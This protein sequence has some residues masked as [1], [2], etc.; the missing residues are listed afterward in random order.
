VFKH[1]SY[2]DAIN[3]SPGQ[4]CLP[5]QLRHQ[6]GARSRNLI[7]M[8]L[9]GDDPR[10]TIGAVRNA[11]RLPVVFPGW[12]LRFY[13]RDVLPQLLDRLRELGA[14]LT[15]VKG[16]SGVPPMLWRMSA[17]DDPLVDVLLSRDADSRLTDR[18]AADVNAWMMASSRPSFH[19]I[20][21]HPSHAA[22]AA[23]G[24]LWG[25][26][27]RQLVRL[28]SG[29]SITALMANF[30]DNYLDD[31]KFLEQHIWRPLSTQF[32]YEVYCHDSVSCDKWVG[33]HPSVTARQWP[34]EHVGQVFDAW[35]RPRQDDVDVL[36]RANCNAKCESPE[37]QSNHVTVG[38]DKD[39]TS[40]GPTVH[41]KICIN[42][43]K[44]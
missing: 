43:R 1:C 35:S 39:E 11:Q 2:T 12:K 19:C 27:R 44:P 13:Y 32:Q 17:L 5:C 16:L 21:D 3:I 28:V 20:R 10:Y 6:P 34:G 7:S 23:N 40:V 14:E 15:D 41:N 24:G 38:H 26:R 29:Q 4:S 36:L 8:S 25:A 22:F 42:Y 37:I 18:D 33:A 9:Y 31:M 30:G